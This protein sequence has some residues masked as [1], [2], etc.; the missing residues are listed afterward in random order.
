MNHET[1]MEKQP[2][3]DESD[4]D[5]SYGDESYG[6]ESYGDEPNNI[7]PLKKFS[8]GWLLFSG[9]REDIFS[10]DLQKSVYGVNYY[11]K[12]ETVSPGNH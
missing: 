12:G 7:P 10:T 1:H 3:G 5:E 9:N 2:Y 6:D 11:S 4:G 8:C